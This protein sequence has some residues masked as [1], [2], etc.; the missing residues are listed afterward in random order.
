VSLGVVTEP[1]LAH[2]FEPLA[3]AL[4][5][6]AGATHP[7]A[8][9]LALVLVVGL[10]VVIGEMVPKNAAVSTPDRAAL[11]LGPPLV[12]VARVAKPVIVVLN[13]VANLVVRALGFEPRDEVSSAFTADEVHSIVTRSSAE[14]T[15]D[16]A[17][18]LL[19]G[20]IEFS[21][22]TAGDVMVP[23]AKVRSVPLGVTVEE[24]ERVVVE[25][26]HS[27]LPI[28]DGVGLVG[29]LHVKDVLY[30]RFG[31]RSQAVDAW[32]I[33]ALPEIP[34][35]AEVEDVLARMRQTGAHVAAV[36]SGGAV[37]GVVFLEDILEILVGEVSQAVRG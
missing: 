24:L 8:A 34:A 35:D 18:G 17:H 30:A 14:G 9:A 10:H 6:P 1:A 5:L 19:T 20:A 3:V 15:L 7:V 29:Y 25:T 2:V 21:D 31:E 13:W 22:R 11:I 4:G 27:R 32:R 12:A 23:L 26:G 28:S 37:V 33:R 36:G 16:D